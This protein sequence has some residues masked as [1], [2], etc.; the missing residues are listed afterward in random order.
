MSL[1]EFLATKLDT[2][3]YRI[4]LLNEI[5]RLRSKGRYFPSNV[6]KLTLSSPQRYDDFIQLLCFFDNNH[7]VNLIDI[8][9]NRGEFTRDFHLFFPKNDFIWCFEP[10]P[11]LR[12][13]LEENLNETPNVRF[14]WIGLGDAKAEAKLKV[15]VRSGALGSFLT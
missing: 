4:S 2:L 11:N 12:A 3:G 7:V 13:I 15:P 14:F 8:G 6:R 9:A 5:S 1:S 10:N